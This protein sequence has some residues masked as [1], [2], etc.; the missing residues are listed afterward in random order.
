MSVNEKMTAIANAIRNKTGKTDK[1]SLDQMATEIEGIENTPSLEDYVGSISIRSRATND[2]VDGD[3]V[4]PAISGELL[5]EYPYA[6][7][8][9]NTTSGYYDLFLHTVPFYYVASYVA[10]WYYNYGALWYRIEIA[11]AAT[12][13]EWTDNTSA[14]D[15]ST[16]K[17]WGVEKERALIW[18]NH[19]IYNEPAGLTDI[20]FACTSTNSVPVD[21]TSVAAGVNWG[22]VQYYF[23]DV[24]TDKYV[25]SAAELKTNTV[26]KFVY[27]SGS[28]D[29]VRISSGGSALNL[30]P[31]QDRFNPLP[32]SRLKSYSFSRTPY[33]DK[34]DYYYST[35][36]SPIYV[37]IK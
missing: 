27:Y 22:S 5:D 13:T 14:M 2:I 19:D 26:Y 9:K 21:R 15:A 11:S 34:E 8:R 31:A 35:T 33:R 30:T 32:L 28:D 16:S 10:I 7:V 18:S 1:L 25:T 3:L 20:Y 24:N 29:Y 17:R 4:L 36:G 6:V 12:A 37:I 23:K